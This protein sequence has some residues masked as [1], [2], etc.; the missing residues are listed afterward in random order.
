MP[1]IFNAALTASFQ[2]SRPI[3]IVAEKVVLDFKLVINSR[4]A[5]QV[6][7]YPE[8][9]MDNPASPTAEWYRE[10]AEEDLGNADARMPPSIRRFST[11][12]A[13]ADLPTGTYYFDTQFKRTHGFVRIQILGF[14]CTAK[15]TAPF[16]EIP[17]AP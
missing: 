9:T 16:G 5:V 15:V 3:I 8:F 14:G 10:T 6:Q 17:S 4:S 11:Q 13:D 2:P 7:W 12:G 1:V